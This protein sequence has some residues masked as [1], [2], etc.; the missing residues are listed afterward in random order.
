MSTNKWR[1]EFSEVPSK[2]MIKYR[3]AFKDISQRFE[4]NH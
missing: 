3:D 1:N 2:V 4:K